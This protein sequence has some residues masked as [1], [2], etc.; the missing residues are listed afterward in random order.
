MQ[1]R[2]DLTPYSRKKLDSQPLESAANIA[3]ITA[4]LL[5]LAVASEEAARAVT[6]LGLASFLFYI[7]NSFV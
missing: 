2:K 1:P 7:K 5:V 6:A 3:V 4:G